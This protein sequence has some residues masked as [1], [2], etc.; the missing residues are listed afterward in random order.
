MFGVWKQIHGYSFDQAEGRCL[1]PLGSRSAQVEKV[2]EGGAWVARHID[3]FVHSAA[4]PDG[5]KDRLVQSSSRWIHDADDFGFPW[6]VFEDI[7][8]DIFCFT[9]NKLSVRH[10]IQLS[11]GFRILNSIFNYFNTDHTLDA[12]SQTQTK[13]TSAATNV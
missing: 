7:N 2:D 12:L 10:S 4:L 9:T 11:V 5:M 6:H 13:R 8:N 3:E 1:D